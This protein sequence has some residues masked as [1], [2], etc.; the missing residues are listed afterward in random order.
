MF[1]DKAEAWSLG[2]QDVADPVVEEIVF[3][4]DR[5]MFLLVII[6]TVVLWLI[7]EALKNKFYDRFLVDG[8]FLEII[9]TIIPAVILVFIA[10]PSLKLLYLMDE[11]VSSALTVKVIGHQWYW[12]YEY[13]DYEGETLGFDSYMVPSSDLT[14]GENRLL[15]V[16]NKLVLPILT[17]TRFLV[18][19][20][21]VLHSFAVPSLGLKI[22]AVPGRL[23]QTGVF[24]K[25]PGVFFG[26]CSEICGANHSFMPIVIKGVWVEEYLH[27][28]KCILSI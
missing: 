19:G 25:R 4:H 15:E 1:Q 24:I 13:S 21:D 12:S 27:F 26:Q 16:D 7:G 20:A 11:V 2:F 14:Q 8:T 3:F 23:N 17:H 18:T 10:L 5:V 22:D 28:L 6:V 9:W